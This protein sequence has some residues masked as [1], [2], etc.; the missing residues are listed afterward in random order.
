[1]LK[2]SEN[3]IKEELSVEEEVNVDVVVDAEDDL[4]VST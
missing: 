3:K 4:D 2:L 1:M